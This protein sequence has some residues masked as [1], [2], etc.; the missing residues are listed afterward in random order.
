[1]NPIQSHSVLGIP[2]YVGNVKDISRHIIATILQRE[3]GNYCVSATGAHGLVQAQ[4]DERFKHILESF[5]LNLPDGMP[6]V[7]VL[8]LKG[9]QAAN[10][11]YGPDVFEEVMRESANQEEVKHFFCGGVEGVARQLMANCESKFGNRNIVGIYSPPF[12][13][14]GK[15]DYQDIANRIKACKANI[16]WI[17]LST[18][19]QEEFASYLKRYA[20]VHFIVTVGAAFDFHT[21]RVTQAPRVLQKSGLEWAFRLFMEPKRLF[22]RYIEIV[23]KFIFYNLKNFF[24]KNNKTLK[25]S[26]VGNPN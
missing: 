20:N 14:V 11:C 13:P 7:W 5:Y 16:V 21:G 22:R 9:N 18:P 17:G 25:K 1:M 12:L 6:G 8:K 15:F 23:P 2:L 26:I 19:K 4:K 3:P 10:R 24:F